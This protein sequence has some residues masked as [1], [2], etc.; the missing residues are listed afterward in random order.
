MIN[1]LPALRDL[2]AELRKAMDREGP[3][4]PDSFRAAESWLSLPVYAAL[5]HEAALFALSADIREIVRRLPTVE[6]RT[7]LGIYLNLDGDH[8]A[9][10]LGAKQNAVSD[11]LGLSRDDIRQ[12]KL[13]PAT[14]EL[15]YTAFARASG[16][17]TNLLEPNGYRVTEARFDICLDEDQPGRRINDMV[18]S[19]E[20]TRDEV[21]MFLWRW[22]TKEGVEIVNDPVCGSQGH[23]FVGHVPLVRGRVSGDR[24]L[25][26]Y[27]GSGHPR[28]HRT[29]IAMTIVSQHPRGAAPSQ[30]LYTPDPEEELVTLTADVPLSLATKFRRAEYPSSTSELPSA[31]TAGWTKRAN[32]D[33]LEFDVP[34]PTP[35]VRYALEWGH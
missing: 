11:A 35:G 10:N 32:G 23:V 33:R 19:V 3:Y 9:S 21:S 1:R 24:L 31:A 2:I 20:T 26:A 5:D 29:D 28:G 16:A 34:R 14:A 27:I 25:C 30:V 22:I 15:A 6:D 18:I 12:R 8:D 4:G 7:L 13:P 17:T